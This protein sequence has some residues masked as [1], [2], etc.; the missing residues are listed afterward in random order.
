MK[1]E[2]LRLRWSGPCWKP[3]YSAACGVNRD[4]ESGGVPL[5][6]TDAV[7]ASVSSDGLTLTAPELASR[8]DG[9]FTA[10]TVEVAGQ[11]RTVLSHV[12]SSLVL[13]S[14][15]GSLSPGAPVVAYKGCNHGTGAGGCLD[16]NNRRR[17]GGTPNVK[18]KNIFL[19]GIQDV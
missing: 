18:K 15:I 6:R 12:G 4:A 11:R 17:F 8:A 7:L 19:V 14:P 3:L 16:F 1:R 9:F 5:Y 13:M 10:G 2:G